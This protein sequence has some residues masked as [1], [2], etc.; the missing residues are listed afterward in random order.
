MI[1]DTANDTT[2][3]FID[4]QALGVALSTPSSSNLLL[5][6]AMGVFARPDVAGVNVRSNYAARFDNF[7]VSN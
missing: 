5:R 3:Y 6:S 1:L 7:R 4:G 2:Q